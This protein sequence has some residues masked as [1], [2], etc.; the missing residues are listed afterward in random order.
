MSLTVRVRLDSFDLIHPAEKQTQVYVEILDVARATYLLP[1]ESFHMLKDREWPDV[2]DAA[3][4]NYEQ[5]W[6]ASDSASAAA[7]KA[8]REWL[9]VPEN[10]DEMQAAFEEDRA[11]RD[12]LLRS[13]RAQV[14]ELEAKLAKFVR[15]AGEDPIAYAL[16]EKAEAAE[17]DA[18]R[19]SVDAQFPKVAEFLAEKATAPAATATPAEKTLIWPD[20]WD[21][22]LDSAIRQWQGEW[23][24]KRV[25]HLYLARY[26]RGLYRS[27]ARNFLS[28][29]A[30]RG[31]LTLHDLPTGRVFT[32]NSRKD[33]R[34]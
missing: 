24:P 23:T 11:A 7:R 10:R 31:L 3:Y 1:P 25:Q 13:L 5:R 2:L 29:R 27:D 18:V 30:H 17:E 33:G 15:P 26:A 14:A 9:A 19:R 32:L 22:V 8:V 4:E 34:A 12:P 28:Q 16:T 20:D 6:I 21:R